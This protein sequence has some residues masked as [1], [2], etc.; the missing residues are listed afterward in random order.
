[1]L[2][3]NLSNWAF[4]LLIEGVGRVDLGEV[5]NGGVLAVGKVGRRRWGWFDGVVFN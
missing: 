2:Q 5:S 4:V 3:G 1:M